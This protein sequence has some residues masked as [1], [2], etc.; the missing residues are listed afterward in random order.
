MHLVGKKLVPL[1]ST[2]HIKIDNYN[3]LN[4]GVTMFLVDAINY[5]YYNIVLR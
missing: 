3:A 1:I 5:G 2:C 4:N